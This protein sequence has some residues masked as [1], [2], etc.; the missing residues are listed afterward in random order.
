M[1]ERMRISTQRIGLMLTAFFMLALIGV[2][3]TYAA[4]IPAM[5]G[6]LAEQSIVRAVVSGDPAAMKSAL[7]GA[8]PLL[9]VTAQQ[10][11]ATLQPD[12]NGLAK[13]AVLVADQTRKASALV[14]YRLRL[15]VIVIGVIAALFGIALLGI[16]E[17]RSTPTIMKAPEQ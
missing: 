14:S 5:R 8:R 17:S 1:A 10:T 13:A 2:F 4:P 11:L 9:G 12:R 7:D 15:L 3:A 6:V 16:G